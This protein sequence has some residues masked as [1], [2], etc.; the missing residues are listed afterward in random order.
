MLSDYIN[1]SP[2]VDATLLV[3]ENDTISS[4]ELAYV[5]NELNSC[6]ANVVGTAL[7]FSSVSSQKKYYYYYNND[8]QKQDQE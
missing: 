5:V 8:N 6:N 2:L 4:R 1:I 7:N 3:V